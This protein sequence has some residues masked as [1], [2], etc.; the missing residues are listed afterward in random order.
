MSAH[1]PS[2]FIDVRAA[3]RMLRVSEGTVR[4]YIHEGRVRARWIGRGY[5]MTRWSLMRD[6]G[7]DELEGDGDAAA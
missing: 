4:R 3:A 5:R 7:L 6:L 1:D 2:E